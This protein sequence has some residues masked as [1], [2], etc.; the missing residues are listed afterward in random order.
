MTVR[1]G[2]GALVTQMELQLSFL[3]VVATKLEW[4]KVPFTKSLQGEVSCFLGCATGFLYQ[5]TSLGWY[6][7]QVELYSSGV[8]T[9]GSTTPNSSR[10]SGGDG[11]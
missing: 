10:K 8:C 5:T 9:S 2:P 1:V 7:H 6:H 3:E 4:A 11:L